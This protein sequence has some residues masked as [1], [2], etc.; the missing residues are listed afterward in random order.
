MVIDLKPSDAWDWAYLISETFWCRF[1]GPSTSP[2]SR[3][4]CAKRGCRND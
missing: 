4:A 3:T 1:G 2:N